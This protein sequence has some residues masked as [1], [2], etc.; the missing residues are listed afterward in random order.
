MVSNNGHGVPADVYVE[1]VL[2]IFH[3][4]I[5]LKSISMKQPLIISWLI[6]G[7]WRA[8]LRGAA[9]WFICSLVGFSVLNL[10]SCWLFS[11]VDSTA[12]NIAFK[13]QLGINQASCSIARG[14]TT[15]QKEFQAILLVVAAAKINRCSQL[16]SL[17][18]LASIFD[19]SADMTVSRVP[20]DKFRWF[21]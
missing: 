2:G 6:S 9:V 13:K 8:L 4:L 7:I 19:W 5:F 3:F 14:T 16:A 15:F 17:H 10:F 1:R 11:S 12:G 20:Y 18:I 21:C